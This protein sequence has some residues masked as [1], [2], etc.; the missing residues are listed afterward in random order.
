MAGSFSDHQKIT[1]EH[2][3]AE[4]NAQKLADPYSFRR[5]QRIH[6]EFF[7]NQTA[8]SIQENIKEKHITT[9]P[10]ESVPGENKKN[11]NQ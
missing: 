1:K 11:E 4:T 6:A 5:I 8:G 9:M 7:N 3:Q 10:E 2:K